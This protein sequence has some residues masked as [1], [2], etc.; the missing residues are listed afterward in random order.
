MAD[1]VVTAG[2]D[3]GHEVVGR[4]EA[5]LDLRARVVDVA[6]HVRRV[7]QPD[8]AL[9]LIAMLRAAVDRGTGR[10]IRDVH[11]IQ[12]DVGGKTGTT[13]NNA[14]GW[15]LLMHPRLV[16][17]AWV[18]FNDQRVTLRSDHWGQGAH[19]ALHVVGDFMHQALD[20]GAVDAGASFPSRMGVTVQNVL[21]RAGEAL[22]SLFGFGSK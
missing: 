6:G 8:V 12:A 20:D 11:A 7:L 10:G 14:D 19:N 3:E 16:A 18:G 1:S 22:R 13:Q 21:R 17:G 4:R 9:Q 15:F 5:Q 2:S